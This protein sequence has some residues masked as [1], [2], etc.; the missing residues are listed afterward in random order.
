METR[1]LLFVL[2]TTKSTE[3]RD[4]NMPF[5]ERKKICLILKTHLLVILILPK[6]GIA[7]G[8]K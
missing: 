7:Y 1:A 2:F 8:E 5:Y 4:K 3:I 6:G